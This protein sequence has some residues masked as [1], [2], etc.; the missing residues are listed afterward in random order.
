MLD[1]MSGRLGTLQASGVQRAQ[2]SP[3]E[4]GLARSRREDGGDAAS[5]SPGSWGL[6]TASLPGILSTEP[7]AAAGN[8]HSPCSQRARWTWDPPGRS[9]G[10]SAKLAPD[11]GQREQPKP[12]LPTCWQPQRVSSGSRSLTV[13]ITR[14]FMNYLCSSWT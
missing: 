8:G 4:G 2:H 1:M 12:K 7:R 13:M 14:D 9:P 6:P 10:G 3:R 5:A 11:Q